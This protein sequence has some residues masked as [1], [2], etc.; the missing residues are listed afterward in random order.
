MKATRKAG[1]IGVVEECRYNGKSY[2]SR[3][4]M[5]KSGDRTGD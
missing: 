3:Q 4:L 1:S 2:E 5:K